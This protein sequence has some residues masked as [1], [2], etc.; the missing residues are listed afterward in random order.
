MNCANHPGAAAVAYCRTCGKPLCPTCARDVRGVIY[1]ENCLAERLQGVQPATP[2]MP[3]PLPPP[4]VAGFAAASAGIPMQPRP[5]SGP[6]PAV[7]GILAGFFP[8]GV[9]AAYEGQYAKG[10]AH[11]LI[12]FGLIFAV[13]HSSENIAPFFALSIAFFYVYQ[14]IDA[15]R[16]AHALQAGQPAPDPLGLG[17]AFGAGEKVDTSRI[18]TT[19]IVLI[20]IGVIFLLQTMGVF[21]FSVD[22]FWPLLL[23]ALGVWLL[24]KRLGWF[25]PPLVS[26]IDYRRG[27]VMGFMGPVVLITVGVL[28][29][30]ENVGGPGW[31]RTWPVLLLAV[32]LTQL[33]TRRTA[34]SQPPMP[35]VG[36][37]PTMQPPAND[38]PPPPSEVNH[39]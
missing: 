23:I 21:S 38:V 32:G 2:I 9:G 22:R 27:R 8:F 10:L 15:V 37:G 1:C 13:S 34:S 28:S 24:G 12:F 29:L 35:P 39:G 19:A 11:L 3:P 6:N 4:P 20:G 16:T 33:M 36:N 26:R 31:D 25:G 30:S 17:Q 18:P 5:G 14:I 7:A